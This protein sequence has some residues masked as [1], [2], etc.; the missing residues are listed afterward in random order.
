MS[1]ISYEHNSR[2]TLKEDLK[3]PTFHMAKDDHQIWHAIPFKKDTLKLFGRPAKSENNNIGR[4]AYELVVNIA[5]N[6]RSLAIGT[7]RVPVT[8]PVCG[9]PDCINTKKYGV[10]SSTPFRLVVSKRCNRCFVKRDSRGDLVCEKCGRIVTQAI[11]MSITDTL[12]KLIRL[13]NEAQQHILRN[14]KRVV[15]MGSLGH[16]IIDGC[17]PRYMKRSPQQL[18]SDFKDFRIVTLLKNVGGSAQQADIPDIYKNM[19]LDDNNRAIITTKM[20]EASVKRLRDAKKV[21]VIGISTPKGKRNI[22]KLIDQPV[23]K[24]LGF[25]IVDLNFCEFGSVKSVSGL[26]FVSNDSEPVSFTS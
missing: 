7:E 1:N 3:D 2:V 8:C 24:L 15:W 21:D 19:F 12:E 22:I 18:R 11:S 4:I 6:P 25:S 26:G 10:P 13:R 9:I 14:G 23:T 5:E 16:P 17:S 20:V